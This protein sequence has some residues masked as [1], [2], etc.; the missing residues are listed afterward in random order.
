MAAETDGQTYV[1]DLYAVVNQSGGL[2][3]ATYDASGINRPFQT[4]HD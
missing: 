2:A 1:Y 4:M 3:G